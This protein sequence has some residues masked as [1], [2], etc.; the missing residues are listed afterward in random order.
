VCGA[1]SVV[2]NFRRNE[3]LRYRSRENVSHNHDV[4]YRL[5]TIEKHNKLQFQTHNRR[6]QYTGSYSWWKWIAFFAIC[7]AVSQ[8]LDHHQYT[9]ILGFVISIVN[10]A[11]ALAE[12]PVAIFKTYFM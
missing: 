4:E 7:W 9:G 3:V 2:T 1:R 11:G 5:K 6:T 8:V 10:I 12:I